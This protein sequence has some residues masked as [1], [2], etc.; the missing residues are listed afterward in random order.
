MRQAEYTA[1]LGQ[2]GWL[3]PEWIDD[4]T[5]LLDRAIARYHGFMDLIAANPR[6]IVVPTVDIVR[7]LPIL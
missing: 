1:A 4:E 2:L 5:A 3:R 6:L 7:T